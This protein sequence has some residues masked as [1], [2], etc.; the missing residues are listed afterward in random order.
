MRKQLLP[1]GTR[2]YIQSIDTGGTVTGVTAH[3]G[4]IFSAS[5]ATRYCA[6][7]PGGSVHPPVAAPEGIPPLAECP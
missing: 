2:N 7:W 3:F 1:C 6:R 4:G 5:T